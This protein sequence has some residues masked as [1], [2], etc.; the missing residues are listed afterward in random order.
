[1]ATDNFTGTNGTTLYTHDNKWT[2]SAG[3]VTAEN[4]DAEINSN[5]LRPAGEWV[6][7]GGYYNNSQSADPQMSQFV[8]KGTAAARVYRYIAVRMGASTNGYAVRYSES[9]GS[10]Y[11]TLEV[12]KDGSWIG[13]ISSRTDAYANDI[14]LKIEASGTSTTTIK[15]YIN[16]TQA[17]SDITDSSSPITTGYPGFIIMGDGTQLNIIDDWTDGVAAGGASPVPL[18]DYY[19]N[20]MRP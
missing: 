6:I 2:D 8:V 20:N 16:G 18:F 5:Q 3:N 10:N 9:S 11:T 7:G 17:G 1:V 12:L 14:T 19:F 13:T 4:T 15:V